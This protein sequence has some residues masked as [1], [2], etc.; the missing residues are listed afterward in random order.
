ME[1]PCAASGLNGAGIEVA[2]QDGALRN[3]RGGDNRGTPHNLLTGVHRR[4]VGV[5]EEVAALV[6]ALTVLGEPQNLKVPRMQN[7]RVR[8]REHRQLDVNESIED[9]GPRR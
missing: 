8:G 6:L 9:G 7:N 5:T 4:A 2:D 3:R 1:M